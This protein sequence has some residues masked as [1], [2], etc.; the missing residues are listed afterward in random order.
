VVVV[1]VA[2][3]AR[4]EAMLGRIALL[5]IPHGIDRRWPAQA[6]GS[7]YKGLGKEK[8]CKSSGISG[9]FGGAGSDC[10]G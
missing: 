6:A 4:F 2:A 5:P 1:N 3:Q 7:V 8:C 10:T 9:N